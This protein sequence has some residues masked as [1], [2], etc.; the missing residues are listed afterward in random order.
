MAADARP[1]RRPVAWRSGCCRAGQSGGAV[2]V[3]PVDG[4]AQ[5][6]PVPR[7][8]GA[9]EELLRKEVRVASRRLQRAA[10]RV[11]GV[12]G[13]VEERLGHDPEEERRGT[14]E[15]GRE[16]QLDR[17]LAERVRLG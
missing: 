5:G 17:A 3:T 13:E 8:G 2:P 15:D 14:E 11:R 16:A 1:G 6:D 12:L 7:F 9:S 4:I 10:E